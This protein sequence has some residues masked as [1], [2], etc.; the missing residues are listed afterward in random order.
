MQVHERLLSGDVE[1]TFEAAGHPVVVK[2][3]LFIPGGVPL[4]FLRPLTNVVE[5]MYPNASVVIMDAAHHI[6]SSLR[7]RQQSLTAVFIRILR[8][9][10]SGNSKA[11]HHF[12]VRGKADGHPPVCVCAH[13]V[14][15]VCPDTTVTQEIVTRVR[16]ASRLP[17]PVP[18]YSQ[19]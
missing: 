13:L 1:G 16:I 8:G 6:I 3:A 2:N 9:C 17:I 5:V 4:Y 15:H 7:K 11:A 10:R 14:L 18:K 19:I 12:F